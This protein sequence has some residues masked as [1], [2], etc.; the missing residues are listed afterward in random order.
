MDSLKFERIIDQKKIK[1]LF[2]GQKIYFEK[3]STVLKTEKRESK[4]L[5][6]TYNQPWNHKWKIIEEYDPDI[7]IIYRPEVMD[8]EFLRKIKAKAISVAYFT[9][10]LPFV[11]FEAEFDL[12]RRFEPFKNYDFESCDFNVTYNEITCASLQKLTEILFS[13]PLPVDDAL[14][15]KSLPDLDKIRGIFYGRV[16]EARNKFLMPLKHNYDWTVID[17]GYLEE[18][19]FRNFNVGLNLHSDSYVNFENR[20]LYHMAQSLLVLSEPIVSDIGLEKNVHY[21]EFNSAQDL[22]EVLDKFNENLELATNLIIAGH[23]K[24]LQFKTSN[25]LSKLEQEIKKKIN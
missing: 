12:V 10:P 9:E 23:N 3:T 18:S 15:T 20:I 16:T 6:Y 4:F 19:F 1:Y 14:F 2:L 25:F 8:P 7:V 5:G 22:Y 21:L 11:G 13:H 24:A 17:H